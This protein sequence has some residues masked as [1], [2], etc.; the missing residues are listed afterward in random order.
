MIQALSKILLACWDKNSTKRPSAEILLTEFS[1]LV[2]QGTGPFGF[3]NPS[4]NESAASAAIDNQI[5]LEA[6]QN[7]KSP[8]SFRLLLLGRISFSIALLSTHLY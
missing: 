3:Y 6:R 4:S 7:V 1:R 8:K 5:R 2:T